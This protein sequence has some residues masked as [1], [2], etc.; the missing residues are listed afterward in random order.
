MPS[1][2]ITTTNS[3]QVVLTVDCKRTSVI[4]SKTLAFSIYEGDLSADGATLTG[5]ML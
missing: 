5:L 2:K 1:N 3:Y 4:P